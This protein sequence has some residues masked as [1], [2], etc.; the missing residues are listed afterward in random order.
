MINLIFKSSSICVGRF[1]STDS[2]GLVST[3][4]K[5]SFFEWFVGLTDGE[6]L[7]IISIVNK[8]SSCSFKFEIGLH[9]DDINM[10]YYIQK[11][12]GLGR[13]A[14]FGNA[15]YFTIST[16]D[17]IA[18][19]LNIFAQYPLKS[20]K[21]LNYLNFKQAFELYT[22]KG[23][24]LDVI[25]DIKILKNNMNSNRTDFEMSDYYLNHPI[26]ITPNWLLGF[27]E[28]EGSFFVLRRPSSN[29]YSL[30]FGLTQSYTNLELMKAIRDYFNNL[31]SLSD[32]LIEGVQIKGWRSQEK[33][34]FAHIYVENKSNKTN[35]KQSDMVILNI[36]RS[37][38][39][40][41]VLIPLFD[42]MIW[43]SKKYLDFQDWKVI[44]SIKEKGLHY[45]SE[46]EELIG[47]ILSQMNTKRLSTYNTKLVDR[48]ELNAGIEKLL[49]QPSNYE[50]KE[51]G[52]IWIISENKYYGD[53][54]SVGVILQDKDGNVISSFESLTACAKSLGQTRNLITRYMLKEQ[55]LLIDNKLVYI[56]RVENS[57]NSSN[58]LESS[59]FSSEW[60]EWLSMVVIWTPILFN[61]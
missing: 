50:V 5:I 41:N 61:T 33:P 6:G 19:L 45:L 26:V 31:P 38:Y 13:V 9:K 21:A 29:S 39:L 28:G 44:F 23:K 24:I 57:T 30:V 12:L 60:Q 17:E 35:N 43:H 8:G 37:E 11:E 47:L 34:V 54:N 3:T 22:N 42:S 18:L 27:V 15:A 59:V 32:S 2:K 1:Y 48:E 16:K 20:N 10:L 55:P 46:G 25:E 51:D 53:K 7:F 40:S 58:M 4:Q 14:T 56:K 52:R 36:T 49:A